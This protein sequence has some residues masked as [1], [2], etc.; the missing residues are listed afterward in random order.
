MCLCFDFELVILKNVVHI[1]FLSYLAG[2]VMKNIDLSTSVPCSPVALLV[3]YYF[4]FVYYFVNYIS[5]IIN[6]Y[7]YLVWLVFFDL[8][9]LCRGAQF[10]PFRILDCIKNSL[11]AQ[12]VIQWVW[13]VTVL[14]WLLGVV[15]WN[16]VEYVSHLLKWHFN[17]RLHIR[18]HWEIKMT[19]LRAISTIAVRGSLLCS[20]CCYTKA[21]ESMGG[22]YISI[23][24]CQWQTYKST[25]LSWARHYHVL[26][27]AN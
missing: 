4:S 24:N 12:T 13:F 11:R 8:S 21:R 10:W 20:S 1:H 14:T 26:H 5:K 22:R 25:I 15:F 3:V 7:S 16:R 2:R 19:S 17:N 23:I 18:F 9:F 6:I 27:W